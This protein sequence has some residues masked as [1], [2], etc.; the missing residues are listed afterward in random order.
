[1]DNNA[2][3]TKSRQFAIKIVQLYKN[4]ANNKKEHVMSEQLLRVGTGIGASLVEAE[5]AANKQDFV[6]K[7][8]E[9]LQKCAATR[10]W[11]EIL[12][13]TDFITEFEYTNGLEDCDELRKILFYTIKSLKTPPAAPATGTSAS[14]GQISTAQ[15]KAPAPQQ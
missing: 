10:Y 2:T 8:Q 1:M 6:A 15:P 13:E 11:L 4:L 7:I 9:A 5:C 3:K 12:K 14:L